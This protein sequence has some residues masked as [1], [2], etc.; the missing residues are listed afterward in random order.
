MH[1]TLQGGAEEDRQVR[2]QQ[3]GGGDEAAGGDHHQAEALD[4]L[5]LCSGLRSR[6]RGQRVHTVQRMWA[7]RVLHITLLDI[8]SSI[9]VDR[10]FLFPSAVA[11]GTHYMFRTGF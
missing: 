8:P 7:G 3:E 6:S 11:R 4:P 5:R 10:I 1:S 2:E 9:V